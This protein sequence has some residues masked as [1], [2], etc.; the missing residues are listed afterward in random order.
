[1][2]TWAELPELPD[3]KPITTPLARIRRGEELDAFV[4]ACI[5]REDRERANRAAGVTVGRKVRVTIT[6]DLHY[7]GAL[8]DAED[9]LEDARDNVRDAFL[10][11]AFPDWL[12]VHLPHGYE[13][14]SAA[15]CEFDDE[16]EVFA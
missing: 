8:V 14:E 5:R 16:G 9:V 13:S 15:E 2:T 3:I 7:T 12:S 4:D 10:G 1:M 6:L 11:D